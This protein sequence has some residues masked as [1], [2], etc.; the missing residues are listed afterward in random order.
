MKSWKVSRSPN[1]TYP[2]NSS[3]QV[4]GALN[5]SDGA[6]R[7]TY[8]LDFLVFFTSASAALGLAGD[9]GFTAGDS[10][11]AAA[12][13]CLDGLAWCVGL[14]CITVPSAH[15]P[16]A[17]FSGRCTG[18]PVGAPFEV[19][20]LSTDSKSVNTNVARPLS[21]PYPEQAFAEVAGL[22]RPGYAVGA[23]G[24]GCGK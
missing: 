12:N 23:V 17:K 21:C 2:L 9:P 20:V 8:N 6:A 19:S 1:V 16:R 14:G 15:I 24:P 7:M 5:L 3:K 11:C 22:E 10:D 4:V 18:P 13:S